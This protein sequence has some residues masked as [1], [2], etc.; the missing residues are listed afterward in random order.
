MAAATEVQ[1]NSQTMCT[2]SIN[3]LKGEMKHQ[4]G[5]GKIE[6]FNNLNRNIKSKM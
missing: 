1:G 5:R 6:P 4:E 3:E 2:I